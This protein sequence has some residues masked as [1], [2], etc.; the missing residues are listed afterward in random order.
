MREK[1][2]VYFKNMK[3]SA[4][5]ILIFLLMTGFTCIISILAL[6][7]SLKIYDRQLYEKS[8]QELDFFSQKISS[9]LD[10]IEDLS[11]AMATGS[12][13]QAQLSKMLDMQYLSADYY[14]ELQ[15]LRSL[16]MNK[17]TPYPDIKNVI[18]T[19]N[20]SVRITMGIMSDSIS[21][22][23]YSDLML[24]FDNAWGGY[25]TCVPGKEYPYLL[26]GRNILQIKSADLQY[27]G[28]LIYTTDVAGILEEQTK[29]LMS[30][31]ATLYVYSESGMIYQEGEVK[32]ME[33]PSIEEQRGYKLVENHGKKYLM[34]YEKSDQTG[35]MF[36]NFLPYT[37]IFGQVMLVKYLLFGGFVV[38]F[39]AM[40]LVMRK[41]ARII[42]N[43][44]ED[45]SES[46]KVV[47][48]GNFSE[49]KV[50]LSQIDRNDE[51]GVL[52]GEFGVMLDEI[53][54]LIHENYEKQLLI[55]NTR[56]KMLQAQINPHFLYNTL[57]AL[58]WMVRG[59]RTKD[60]AKM[61]M[62]LG[63]LLRAS[64]ASDPYT[65]VAEEIEAA[66][67]YITIQQFR[68]QNRAQFVVEAGDNL[69]AYMIPRMILQPLIEN[70]IFY[71]VEN[72][73]SMCKVMVKVWEQG[74]DIYL[75][76]EDEG[77]GMTEEKLEEV[78]NGTFVPNGQGIGLKNIRE[79][80]R[81]AFKES[82]FM[83]DSRTGVGT[84]VE[85]RIPKVWEER[86]DV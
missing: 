52:V 22:D 79:R 77:P 1:L 67:S 28:S 25:V 65:T 81:I 66:K 76:V 56:Y 44:L 30:E 50:M 46:M 8:Q 48:T 74:E 15:E 47:E 42:T 10:D 5:M 69:E 78:R 43:P 53:E 40:V 86:K 2:K 59:E 73:L 23:V 16:L 49:A 60:A 72:S 13:V 7:A 82:R 80:L 71:G 37:E 39:L 62:E 64:F 17:V 3:L 57:N 12:D 20:K 34:C 32:G 14:Y 84:K 18:F 21:E 11:L 26:S 24:Q 70:A 45:L 83:V 58:N 61:I 85:I 4:K 31:H 27:M 41:V 55:Q 35:W 51:I 33:L 36:V 9:S 19:D 68:Y 75:V 54:K 29:R 63:K 38:I 6:Q